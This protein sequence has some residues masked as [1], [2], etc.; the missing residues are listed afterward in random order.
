MMNPQLAHGGD[1][2]AVRG[3]VEEAA[4]GLMLGIPDAE[5]RAWPDWSQSAVKLLPG[6]PELF[7]GYHVAKPP[8]YVRPKT[9]AM[10]TGTILHACCLE[11]VSLE[12]FIIPAEVLSA[13]GSRAGTA[14]KAWEAARGDT[15]A[16]K[17]NEAFPLRKMLGSVFAE[18]QAAKLLRAPGPIEV[19]KQWRHAKTGLP[20]KLRADKIAELKD[21]RVAIDLKSTRDPTERG[22]ARACFDLGYHRQAA[23]YL[24]GLCGADTPIDRLWPFVFIAVR[25]E[26]PYE[27]FVWELSARS[28]DLGR[29]END[30]ALADLATRLETDNWHGPQFGKV[31]M[32]DLPKWAFTR[33]ENL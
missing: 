8:L 22:F 5:Y 1:E 20:M 31:N 16:I 4:D 11:G 7:H 24:D 2:A 26:P 9:A 13:S 30:A 15:P 18:P 14:W 28:I 19:C 17:A 12:H 32:I 33:G 25:N 23:W 10:D 21:T 29:Q 6:G 27:C 3:L